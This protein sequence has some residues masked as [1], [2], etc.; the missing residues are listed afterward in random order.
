MS[1][2]VCHASPLNDPS[3]ILCLFLVMC[4]PIFS[5][6]IGVMAWA[7]LLVLVICYLTGAFP[8]TVSMIGVEVGYV[9]EVEV[10]V[11]L[12]RCVFWVMRE[13]VYGGVC[14]GGVTPRAGSLFSVSRCSDG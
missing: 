8:L 1:S 4:P 14:L 11:A 7:A 6:V 9:H 10:L 13:F 2:C 3:V 5:Y 12:V